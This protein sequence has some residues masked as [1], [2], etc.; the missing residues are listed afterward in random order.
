MGLHIFGIWVRIFW[1]VESLGIKKYRTICGTK[2]RV[3]YVFCDHFNKRVSP[4]YNDIV[5][6]IYKVD[7]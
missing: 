4:S 1:H 3:K 2:M 6:R 7:A 5:K